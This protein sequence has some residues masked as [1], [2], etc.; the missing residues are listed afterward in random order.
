MS[1]LPIPH[2]L[3]V[4]DVFLP[5]LLI[6]A[7]AGLIL[8]TLTSRVFDHYRLS[9]YLFFPPLVLLSLSVI[10]TVLIGTLITGI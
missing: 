6:A 1:F 5:P 10:Y 4:G 2:E 9:Q 8:A 7:M 3:A